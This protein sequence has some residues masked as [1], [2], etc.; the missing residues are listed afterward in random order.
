MSELT[1]EVRLW[2]DAA[3][4]QHDKNVLQLCDEHERLEAEHKRI[5]T[6]HALLV[7]ESSAQGREL[8]RLE[9]LLR[10]WGIEGDI[11]SRD[12]V[13]AEA[14]RLASPPDSKKKP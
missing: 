9:G 12:L 11:R 3:M 14:V 10:R 1:K 13:Y 2:S 8:R 6:D 7:N 4:G 5:C